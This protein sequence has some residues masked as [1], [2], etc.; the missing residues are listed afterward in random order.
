[1]KSTEEIWEEFCEEGLYVKALRKRDGEIKH[2]HIAEEFAI[3]HIEKRLEELKKE[4]SNLE[5]EPPIG[6]NSISSQEISVP[7]TKGKIIELI[8]KKIEEN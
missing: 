2:K 6:T 5:F 1:M 8:N 3:F 4:I 7:L